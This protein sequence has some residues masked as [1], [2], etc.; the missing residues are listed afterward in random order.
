MKKTLS[1]ILPLLLAFIL[2]VAPVLKI[3]LMQAR[4]MAPCAWG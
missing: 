1:K 3:V 2:Q 4:E